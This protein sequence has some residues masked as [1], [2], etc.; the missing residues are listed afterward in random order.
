M[1]PKERSCSN[2]DPTSLN[3][4]KIHRGVEH[5]QARVQS[6]TSRRRLEAETDLGRDNT[7]PE[8]VRPRHRKLQLATR[9]GLRDSRWVTQR[10]CRDFGLRAESQ[11]HC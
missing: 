2:R 4:D 7:A 10:W 6:Q 8:G 11:I 5:V 9:H 1:R 3:G